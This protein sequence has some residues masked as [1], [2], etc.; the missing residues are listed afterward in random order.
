G[1]YTI[2]LKQQID[3]ALFE[4]GDSTKTTIAD[5][6]AGKMP[7]GAVIGY[8]P[9]LHTP[10]EIKRLAE[11]G[12]S[13]RALAG[14]P[15]DAIWADRPEAPASMVE[16]FPAKWAGQSVAEKLDAAAQ[17]L[18]K[19]G[20]EA[21]IITLPDSIAWLLNVRANDIPH[22]PVALSNAILKNDGTLG[23][24]IAG[25]RVPDD[26]RGTFGN[27][28]SIL[29][30]ETLEREIAKF[31]GA[32]ILV[33]GRRTSAWFF[34]LLKAEGIEVIDAK[35]P[36]IALKARKNDAEKAAMR[37]AH[38]R[39]G[40]A[41]TKF[42]KWLSEAGASGTLTELDVEAKLESF[43]REAPE[44]RDSSFDTI[45]GYG[46]NGAIVHYRATRE[47]NARIMPGSLLLVDS[48]AQYADG[49]TDITRTVAIGTPT[50]E[51]KERFTLVLKGHIALASAR[52]PAGTTGAQLDALARAPLW[53][54]GLDFAH[55][56]GHGVGCY[57]S[58]HE[59]AASISPRGHDALEPGMII[60]NEPG[61]YEEGAYGIRTEN[62]I[63]VQEDGVCAVTGKQMLSFE[64][65]T[66]A[67]YDAALIIAEMLDPA[68]QA[69]L[70]A[71]NR[72]AAELLGPL[73]DGAT[74]QW[75][76]NSIR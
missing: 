68:E 47:T 26:V 54:E 10:Q 6:V 23:W 35:D 37:A 59:E 4:T 7:D 58:V 67:P 15:L 36:V 40:A 46:P 3:P 73:L 44:Y 71:Y 30:P 11:K 16:S 2:Q 14:N 21:A 56:T 60:S 22:I 69:W 48:G 28:A 75:L 65:L 27:R 52:F 25:T 42:L 49:T 45:A 29:P 57:L 53:R 62:L 66:F 33:D 13:L 9:R 51:M 64:T 8:D 61:Y 55:G 43:R 17:E 31:K 34:D 1:R 50:K 20:A 63:L 39:D 76:L 38:I 18:A 5:W 74:K 41:V 19:Q 72:K 12:L 24:F 70:A 32:K